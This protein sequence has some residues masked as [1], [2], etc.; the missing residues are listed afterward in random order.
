MV[1]NKLQ[2]IVVIIYFQAINSL[3]NRYILQ[4]S[5]FIKVAAAWC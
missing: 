1:P 3:L 5:I 2:S 4:I